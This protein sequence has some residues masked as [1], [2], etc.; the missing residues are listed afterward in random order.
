[1]VY[2]SNSESPSLPS[3]HSFPRGSYRLEWSVLSVE[4]IGAIMGNMTFR[5]AC[6]GL[7]WDD[8]FNPNAVQGTVEM[9]DNGIFLN[10]SFGSIL[11]D[12]YAFSIGGAARHKHVDYLYGLS[13]DGYFLALSDA[14]SFGTSASFPGGERQRI[15]GKM[16]FAR[17]GGGPFDP[18]SNVRAIQF[19]MEGL[20]EWLGS[21]VFEFERKR[22]EDSLTLCF[23]REK[24]MSKNVV[25][26]ENEVLSIKV[27]HSYEIP[28]MSLGELTFRHD[29][30][31]EIKFKRSAVPLD[32]ALE[33]AEKLSRFVTFCVGFHAGVSEVDVVLEGQREKVRLFR[34]MLCWKTPSEYQLLHI[35]FTYR[36]IE[37]QIGELLN[38]WMNAS[39][40]LAKARDILISLMAYDWRMP[41]DV[42]F[43]TT[44]QALEA[45]SR[46]DVEL[47]AMEESAFERRK[48]MIK[49]A[50]RDIDA[51]TRC[52]VM[53]RIGENRKGQDRLLKELLDRYKAYASWLVPDM[54]AFAKDQVAARNWYSHR[55]SGPVN[56]SGLGLVYHT[57]LVQ[58]L[59]Y[60]IVWM[61]IG[62]D[63]V[64]L[65]DQLKKTGYKS[66]VI[67]RAREKY[68]LASS[69]AASCDSSDDC[70]K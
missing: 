55:R 9:S 38:S 35:P 2:L 25:L 18:E 23:S 45:L 68:D 70:R 12:A 40:E 22:Q 54:K 13:Q 17:K 14:V 36:S 4:G 52:W 28:E 53:G 33:T 66:D 43:V 5:P 29:C 65:I 15:N 24:A 16:L 67:A 37:D 44:S 30:L 31:A 51:D 7:S 64:S 61:K 57:Q 58:M 46:H 39:A 6:W 59:M 41:I 42:S 49:A 69:C 27:F 26:L 34:Q 32:E 3:L 8:A 60:G 1:M 21:T 56:V 47:K 20:K 48:A 62:L 11:E 19:R 63:S 50:I 10:T